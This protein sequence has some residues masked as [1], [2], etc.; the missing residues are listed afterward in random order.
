MV[1]GGCSRTRELAAGK[2][3]MGAP[4]GRYGVA[5]RG[6]RRSV[7][8]V[9]EHRTRSVHIAGGQLESVSGGHLGGQQSP[10]LHACTH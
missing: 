2:H 6:L 1:P 9:S 7:G 3:H 4:R 8:S 5:A 10:P